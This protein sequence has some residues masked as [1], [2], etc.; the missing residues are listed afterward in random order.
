M[1][2]DPRVHPL[3]APESV[4]GPRDEAAIPFEGYRT[5]LLMIA[6]EMMGPG[7]RAK[8]GASD[9]VQEAL[10]E[11]HE[12]IAGFRGTTAIELRA[13]LR[14]ILRCRL[15]NIERFYRRTKR[16]VAREVRLE[17]I[18]A[19]GSAASRPSAISEP[20]PSKH[21]VRAEMTAALEAAIDR[22]PAKYRQAIV[23]RHRQGLSF[24]EVGEEIGCTEEAARK[25]WGRGILQLR[26]VLGEWS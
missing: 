1:S 7:L 2:H 9:V 22:L 21:A 20:S 12:H 15:A 16:S 25:L 19:P 10:L 26:R 11:A 18:E 3:R 23:L 17:V 6:H 24:R 13:W 14:E 5:Y 8:L 4:V